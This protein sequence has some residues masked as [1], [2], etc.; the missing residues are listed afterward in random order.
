MIKIRHEEED[1][2]TSSL[3]IQGKTHREL[4]IAAG[5]MTEAGEF[6]EGIDKESIVVTTFVENEIRMLMI[7]GIRLT[8]FQADALV[9]FIKGEI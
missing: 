6:V 8:G 7:N 5:T 4:E 1:G 9:K 2:T 3:T